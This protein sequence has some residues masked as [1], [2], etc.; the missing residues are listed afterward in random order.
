MVRSPEDPGGA[1]AP[2]VAATPEPPILNTAPPAPAAPLAAPVVENKADWNSEKWKDYLDGE[3]KDDPSLKV[4]KDIKGLA[5]IY[6]DSQKLIGADKILVPNKFASEAEWASIYNKLGRPEAADKYEVVMPKDS[7]MS[8]DF[9]KNLKEEAYASGLNNTQANKLITFYDKQLVAAQEKIAQIQETEYQNEVKGLKQEWG[10]AYE[11]KIKAAEAGINAFGDPEFL[12]Y[13]N[14]SGLNKDT[15]LAKFF[16]KIGEAL[17][18]EQ[19]PGAPGNNIKTPA[20]AKA[21]IASL[22]SHPAYFDG[23]HPEHS[24]IVNQVLELRRLSKF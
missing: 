10:Q 17:A 16:A 20:Q 3:I 4:V 13:L 21:E 23:T 19:G 2:P 11:S 6:V 12:N 1:S 15:R 7:K 8:E 9:V 14:E 24:H 18:E 22:E 5:K